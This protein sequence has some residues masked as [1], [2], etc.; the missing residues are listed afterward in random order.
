LG[1]YVKSDLLRTK[2]DHRFQDS[3]FDYHFKNVFGWDSQITFHWL[4][5][6]D[7]QK[8]NNFKNWINSQFWHFESVV[9]NDAQAK[10]T[11]PEN[12]FSSAIITQ[13]RRNRWGD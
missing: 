5:D 7:P 13:S 3:R 9:M 1:Y 11:I 12:S 2:G 4:I 8:V 6:G 10:K